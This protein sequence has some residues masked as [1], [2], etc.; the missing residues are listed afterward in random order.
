MLN[1]IIFVLL[2]ILGLMYA[3]MAQKGVRVKQVELKFAY[4]DRKITKLRY[5]QQLATV[6]F[7][8]VFLN[9]KFVLSVD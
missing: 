6:T 9:P 7:L 8:N 2:I 1:K 4:Q 5:E 3:G